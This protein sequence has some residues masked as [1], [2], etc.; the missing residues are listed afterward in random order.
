MGGKYLVSGW[1]VLGLLFAAVVAGCGEQPSA[2]TGTPANTETL[3]VTSTEAVPQSINGWQLMWNDEFNGAE[4]SKPDP[5]KWIVVD[6]HA[7]YSDI[8]ARW[9]PDDV[10]MDGQGHVVFRGRKDVTYDGTPEDYTSGMIETSTMSST[11]PNTIYTFTY[12]KVEIRA[13]VPGGRGLWPA[14]WMCNPNIWPPEIDILDN[15]MPYPDSVFKVRQS[16]SGGAEIEYDTGGV[17]ISQDYHTYGLEWEPGSTRYYFDDKLTTVNSS[18]AVPSLPMYLILNLQIG[19]SWPGEPDETTVFPAYMYVDYVRVY[20]CPGCTPMPTL[21]PTPTPLPSATPTVIPPGAI[22]RIDSGSYETYTDLQGNVWSPDSNYIGGYVVDR[23]AD[24]AID[25]TAEGAAPERVYQTERWGLP[26]YAIPLPNGWYTVKLHFAETAG[27]PS[28]AGDRVMS[29]N[30]EGALMEGIDAIAETGSKFKALVKSAE[31]YVGDGVLN[32][33]WKA[34]ADDPMVDGIEILP[35]PADKATPTPTLQPTLAPTPEGNLNLAMK[36][37]ATSSSVEQGVAEDLP[38]EQAVDGDPNT[39]WSADYGDPQWLM[40]DLGSIKHISRV[41][42][43]WE[44]AYAK[45]YEI[46]VSDD[47]ETWTPIYMTE[48]GDGG[49]DDLTGLDGSGCYV[50]VLGKVR[51]NNDWTYSIWEFEVYE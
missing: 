24:V 2:T 5:A 28:K 47:G 19:G 12:G 42:I 30:A 36:R 23:G 40:V 43:S 22:V 11:N 9:T 46:Q 38:P 20:Q 8:M 37:P 7:D 14:L 50:R 17:D 25:T 44:A 3:T 13:K 29:V 33:D 51:F 34:T 10:Y 35:G 27:G 21:S 41:R 32:L 31:V 1:A 45:F 39:R 49:I 18:N 15:G 26:G 48:S 4:G 6:G 16:D